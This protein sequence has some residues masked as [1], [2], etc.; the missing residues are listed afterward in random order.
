MRVLRGVA[1]LLLIAL[2]AC[3]GG[4]DE[5]GEPLVSGSVTGEWDGSSFALANGFATIFMDVPLIGVGDGPIHCGSEN[6]N[7]PPSGT[8]A[9]IAVPA[10]EVGAYTGVFVE[11]YHNVDEFEGVG[12]NAG[13]LTLDQVSDTSIAG[14][15]SY[16]MTDE[17]GRHFALSGTFEVVRCAP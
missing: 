4:D 8:S 1:A 9:A 10:F 6:D 11:L 12:S 16:D 5:S 17:N 3:G 2:C 13:S 7:D 14:S 15:V